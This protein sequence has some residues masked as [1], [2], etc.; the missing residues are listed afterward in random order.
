MKDVLPQGK[1]DNK[2]STKYFTVISS[3]REEFNHGKDFL[4]VQKK[5]RLRKTNARYFSP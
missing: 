4:K 5:T 1:T 2:F 3:C